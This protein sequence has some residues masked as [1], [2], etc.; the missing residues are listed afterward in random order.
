MIFLQ[1]NVDVCAYGGIYGKLHGG[2]HHIDHLRSG[3]FQIIQR[4]CKHRR[5]YFVEVLDWASPIDNEGIS[6]RFFLSA[7]LFIYS[8]SADA[9]RTQFPILTIVIFYAAGYMEP[10]ILIRINTCVASIAY[11]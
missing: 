10:R 2:S 8:G 3:G 4:F 11:F 1:I 9:A 5:S 6:I 7:Q